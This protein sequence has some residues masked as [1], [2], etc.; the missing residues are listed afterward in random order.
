VSGSLWGQTLVMA[1]VL[2]LVEMME[3][4]LVHLLVMELAL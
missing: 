3:A 1:L 2:E 4:L